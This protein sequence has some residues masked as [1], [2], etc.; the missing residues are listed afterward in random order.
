M[1]TCAAWCS[2]CSASSRRARQSAPRRED[3]FQHTAHRLGDTRGPECARRRFGHEYLAADM[4]TTAPHSAS[5]TAWLVVG[6]LVPVALLNYLDRQMLATMKASM[7]SDIPS[8][9]DK[10][11]WG[12]I[13]GSFKWTYAAFS[14]FGGYIADR[15][16]RRGVI[17]GSLFLWSLVT[18]WTGHVTRFTSY[19]RPGRSWAS[20]RRSTCPPRWRSLRITTR[21]HPVARDGRAYVPH[22]R[23]TNLGGFAGYVADSPD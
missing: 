1:R 9:A 12:L 2:T 18:W 3:L 5:R 10:A 20:A 8:I 16:G 15:F 14:P 7:V 21:H 17:C 6:L 19:W 22:L 4:K 11:D 13:L 23:R